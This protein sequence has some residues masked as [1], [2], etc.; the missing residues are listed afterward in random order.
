MWILHTPSTT[1][2]KRHVNVILLDY[3]IQKELG[4][5]NRLQLQLSE[6]D[7]WILHALITTSRR[8]A[9]C[10]LSDYNIQRKLGQNDTP[11]PQHSEGDKWILHTPITWPITHIQGHPPGYT[12]PSW[13]DLCQGA[14]TCGEEKDGRRHSKW[15][16]LIA[17]N[18]PR[19]PIDNSGMITNSTSAHNSSV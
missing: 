12:V 18:C 17:Q 7:M 9:K 4:Q 1:S 3:N 14:W 13:G 8:H 6:G 10:I 19:W 2:R 15:T 5:N 16:R 11:Q